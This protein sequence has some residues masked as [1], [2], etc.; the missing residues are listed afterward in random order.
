MKD[1]VSE[2]VRASREAWLKHR[3]AVRELK[4][5]AD[6]APVSASI[7]FDYVAE[8]LRRK[9]VKD[10]YYF[11]VV[12]RQA[13]YL[14]DLETGK[15]ELT[16]PY[17]LS[18]GEVNSSQP[19]TLDFD[20]EVGATLAGLQYVTY[21]W[22]RINMTI[23]GEESYAS[24]KSFYGPAVCAAFLKAIDE[25]PAVF[26]GAFQEKLGGDPRIREAALSSLAGW[27]GARIN[28]A[29]NRRHTQA[30]TAQPGAKALDQFVQLLPA[31]V[32]IEWAALS[33]EESPAVLVRGVERQIEEEGSQAA[34]LHRKGKL[35]E[36]QAEPATESTEN[37]LEEFERNE[38]LRQ[39]L[40]AL[41]GWVEKAG[42][43]ED[44][45]RVYEL[46][47]QTDHDTELIAQELGKASSTVR[48]H[49][50][51]YRDKVRKVR[52]D[53]AL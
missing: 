33:R 18:T 6:F 30:L 25:V 4:Q 22:A 37:D 26:A 35:A 14:H 50:K 24:G 29:P 16:E 28:L 13:R 7:E 8:L 45:A 17:N 46:D 43:S 2:A 39:E 19:Y 32:V 10:F 34:K 9:A 5:A 42:F 21:K 20:E 27:V 40:N 49:R 12:S 23:A 41:R 15:V 3:K 36:G 31:A 51:R 44:E 47:M 53:A 48:Q 1:K 52:D 11:T 38:T